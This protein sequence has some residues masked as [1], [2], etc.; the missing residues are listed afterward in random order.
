MIEPIQVRSVLFSISLLLLFLH[1]SPMLGK[2]DS[3]L[4]RFFSSFTLCYFFKTF[5]FSLDSHEVETLSSSATNS[6]R[7][8]TSLLEQW[9]NSTSSRRS[10]WNKNSRLQKIC[11]Q[12]ST[13]FIYDFLVVH[14]SQF[15]YIG[16]KAWYLSIYFWYWCI[17]VVN[18]SM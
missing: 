2:K 16:W 9:S 12:L 1:F 17:Y 14:F 10:K 13:W 6:I 5:F 3:V 15:S 18:A 7:L 4:F 11:K 8:E